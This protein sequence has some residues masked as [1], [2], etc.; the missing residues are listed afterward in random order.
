MN[1][2]Q[3]TTSVKL[4][5]NSSM[6]SLRISENRRPPFEKTLENKAESF[7][8]AGGDGSLTPNMG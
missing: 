2:N 3:A 8:Q 4:R 1:R 7:A 5:D 6:L